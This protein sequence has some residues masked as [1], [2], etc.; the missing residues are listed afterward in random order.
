MIQYK[1]IKIEEKKIEEEGKG[2]G[3]IKKGIQKNDRKKNRVKK[4]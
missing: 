2:I 3:L 1:N 4:R